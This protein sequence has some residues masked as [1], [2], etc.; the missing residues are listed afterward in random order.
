[1]RFPSATIRQ[2]NM[3]HT[4]I[5]AGRNKIAKGD[6]ASPDRCV[7]HQSRWRNS[8]LTISREDSTSI[9]RRANRSIAPLLPRS[10]TILAVSDGSAWRNTT[11]HPNSF[12][13]AG[14]EKIGSSQLRSCRRRHCRSAIGRGRLCCGAR[15]I[16]LSATSCSCRPATLSVR[17]AELNRQS[18]SPVRRLTIG[19]PLSVLLHRHH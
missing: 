16:C 9:L 12:A 18:M 2:D 14:G 3:R 15:T 4:P 8:A 7:A 17:Y 6:E 10:L 11:D 13:T 19:R 1:M 5:T